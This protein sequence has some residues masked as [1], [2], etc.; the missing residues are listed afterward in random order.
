MKW[1]TP[2]KPDST[3]VVDGAG[4]NFEEKIGAG[5]GQALKSLQ[6]EIGHNSQYEM[7]SSNSV[8]PGLRQSYVQEVNL[9][10]FQRERMSGMA[11]LY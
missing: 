4:E 2:A 9:M 10:I 11:I 5:W 3:R 7:T 6:E 1:E 8:Y